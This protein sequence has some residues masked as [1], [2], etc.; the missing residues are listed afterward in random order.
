[1]KTNIKESLLSAA[2]ALAAAA[3]GTASRED[4]GVVAAK[5]KV[6]HGYTDFICFAKRIISSIKSAGILSHLRQNPCIR[7]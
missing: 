1:M 6:G 2:F 5:I 7:G 3:S 4:E